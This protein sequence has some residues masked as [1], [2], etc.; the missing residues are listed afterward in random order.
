MTSTIDFAK[1]DGLVDAVA[2]AKAY[3]ARALAGGATWRLGRG[4]GPL[5][6]FGWSS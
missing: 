4:H 2:A 5:D 3:V 6:H 1:G